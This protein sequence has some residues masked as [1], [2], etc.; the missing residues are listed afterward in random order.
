M[1]TRKSSKSRARHPAPRPNAWLARTATFEIDRLLTVLSSIPETDH[2]AMVFAAK[3]IG[4]RV[5][6]ANDVVRRVVDGTLDDGEREKA[7]AMLR[8]NTLTAAMLDN[9]PSAWVG[10]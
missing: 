7:E 5:R 10:A 8:E 4:A 2:E 6:R 1:A 9:R 3:G